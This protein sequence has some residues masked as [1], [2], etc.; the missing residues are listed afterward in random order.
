MGYVGRLSDTR[1]MGLVLESGSRERIERRIPRKMWMDAVR[2]YLEVETLSQCLVSESFTQLDATYWW[3]ENAV[4]D[5]LLKLS[6]L[7]EKF[8]KF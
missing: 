1:V 4:P 8:K 7:S 6:S 2:E 5:K 3:K